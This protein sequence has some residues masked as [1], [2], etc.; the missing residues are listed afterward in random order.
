MTKE[1]SPDEARGIADVLVKRL[2]DRGF[3]EALC[4]DP[5]VALIGAGVAPEKAE[6]IVGAF[7]KLREAQRLLSQIDP[8]AAAIH[9]VI[10]F[11][12]GIEPR[13]QVNPCSSCGD[14]CLSWTQT[15]C[16]PPPGGG[17]ATD[18]VPGFAARG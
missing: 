3:V 17:F 6:G 16:P 5:V 11:I 2:R 9:P 7:Q 14:G 15:Y 18:P 10:G 8:I 12:D 13:S 4:K 1:C